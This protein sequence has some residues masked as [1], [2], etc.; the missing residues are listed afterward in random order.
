MDNH[1]YVYAYLRE[2]GT[3]YYIGKGSGNR[4]TSSHK[5]VP[6][7]KDKLRIQYVETNLTESKAFD[8]EVLL[9][10][11]WGRKDINT[12]ILLNRSNGGDCPP[13][14]K[15]STMPAS[16][17]DK[18]RKASTGK[19][20]SSETRSNMSIGRKGMKFTDSHR[21]NLSRSHIGIKPTEQTLVKRSNA[22][23]GRIWWNNGVLTKFS[24]T[25]PGPDWVIGRKLSKDF[26]V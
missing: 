4:A 13:S 19:K 17:V 16:A 11:K 2:D 25:S 15:G 21:E 26:N 5:K 1:F 3:P 20:K 23:K 8:L 24:H 6:V 9:I 18:I 14:R 12:G 10:S 7:P 22:F